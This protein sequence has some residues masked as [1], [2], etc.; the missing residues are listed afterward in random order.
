MQTCFPNGAS[1][2]S[3]RYVMEKYAG[4]DKQELGKIKKLGR[5]S[6]WF[7][8]RRSFPVVMMHEHGAFLRGSDDREEDMPPA[9][10]HGVKRI[11]DEGDEEDGEESYH[12]KGSGTDKSHAFVPYAP[13]RHR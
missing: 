4:L 1:A 6:R 9:P 8:I 13:P 5:F 11:R 12:R 10:S 7:C 2:H 3:I